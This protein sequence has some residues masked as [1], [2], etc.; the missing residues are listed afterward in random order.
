MYSVKN[1]VQKNPVQISGAVI[2][3][4]NVLIIAGWV[5]LDAKAV[6]A[7]NTA[8]IAVLGLFVSQATV[9]AAAL[10]DAIDTTGQEKTPGP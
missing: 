4:L 9:N 8:L 7:L 6:A 10:R 5:V 3:V 2:A 1:L